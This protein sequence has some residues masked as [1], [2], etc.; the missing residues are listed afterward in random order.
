LDR[1]QFKLTQKTTA[2][3]ILKRLFSLVILLFIVLL[4]GHPL[5]PSFYR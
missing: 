1:N 4:D 5:L 3:D 2:W